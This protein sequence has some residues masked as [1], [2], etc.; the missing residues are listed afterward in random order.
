MADPKPIQQDIDIKA[1]T[2][3]ATDVERALQSVEQATEKAS[4][5]SDKAASSDQKRKASINALEAE[6][7]NLITE[8]RS[9]QAALSRAGSAT[10]QD[11]QATRERRQEIDRLSR[12]LA[13]LEDEQQHVNKE[14][15]SSVDS[16]RQSTDSVDGLSGSMTGL[17]KGLGSLGIALSAGSAVQTGLRLFREELENVKRAR[18][19]AFG[20]Q[21]DLASAQR[22]LKLNLA[23]AD[24]ATIQSAIDSAGQIAQKNSVP[25]AVITEALA[26]ALSSTDTNL[27]RAVANTSLAARVR[28]DRSDE[29]SAFAGAIGDIQNSLGT[30]DPEVA[31][32]FL[33]ATQSKSRIS[34]FSQLG[35]AVP[36]AIKSL[37]DS[38]FSGEGAG[39]VFS[40]ITAG[41]T[42]TSGLSSQTASI[43]F[44]EQLREFLNETG[45]TELSSEQGIDL[46]RRDEALREQF[47]DELSVEA[48]ARSTVRGFLDPASPDAK[49]FDTNIA[50]FGNREQLDALALNKLRQLETGPV[51]G[52]ASLGRD[53]DA[54]F[55]QLAGD[56][57]DFATVG[58]IQKKLPS[59]LRQAGSSALAQKITD[60]K[61]ELA[62]FGS[63]DNAL[64]FLIDEL[65]SEVET[66]RSRAVTVS[67]SGGLGGQTNKSRRRLNTDERRQIEILQSLVYK[68]ETRRGKDAGT[69]YIEFGDIPF[70]AE[71]RP[72]VGDL[73]GLRKEIDRPGVDQADPNRAPELPQL[74]A[75]LQPAIEGATSGRVF[76]N[77][78]NVYMS[79]GDYMYDDLDGSARV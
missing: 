19:E 31:L 72:G 79:T 18:D 69:Q 67:A 22:S 43:A 62:D 76:N 26:S 34:D 41:S 15:R 2:K 55:D 38:G 17:V 57:V 14:M 40:A 78:A 7:K 64:D 75:D 6:I 13:K 47:L 4:K 52:N 30:D 8:E 36:P 65:E 49:R 39:A 10:E 71:G 56:N 73:E 32:G 58:A 61:F 63:T 60:Y 68:I 53:L 74:P 5:T 23:D 21:V 50:S 29:I 1:N 24:D 42:D 45:N 28:P 59:V 66:I 16:H 54:T 70:N 46:L 27:D 3:G 48:R 20:V 35:T 11:E 37:V 77:Y 25:E 12:S 44:G 51:E 33:L 9:H